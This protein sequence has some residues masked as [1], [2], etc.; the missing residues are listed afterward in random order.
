MKTQAEQFT[1]LHPTSNSNF[2][3]R[4]INR[5]DPVA[6]ADALD[7]PSMC[8]FIISDRGKRLKLTAPATILDEARLQRLDTALRVPQSNPRAL[9]HELEDCQGP[10]HVHT[11]MEVVK[12]NARPIEIKIL[13]HDEWRIARKKVSYGETEEWIRYY[14]LRHKSYRPYDMDGC[15]LSMSECFN[16]AQ[17]D[18]P[19]TVY[20]AHPDVADSV[21]PIEL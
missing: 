18:S 21:F 19:P 4:Q 5:S 20:L 13:E 14:L 7:V 8:S 17:K 16:A 10:T 15:E 12:F 6:M 9:M 2:R 11:G 1:V 3:V